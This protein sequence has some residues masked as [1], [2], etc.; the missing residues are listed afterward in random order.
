MSDTAKKAYSRFNAPVV[1][2]NEHMV[3]HVDWMPFAGLKQS[4]LGVGGK[5]YTMRKM[6]IEKLIVLR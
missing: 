4:E 5:P 2:I 3:F 6:Q 1:M